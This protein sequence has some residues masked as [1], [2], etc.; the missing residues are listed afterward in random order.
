M[1]GIAGYLGAEAGD[2]AIIARQL[3][4]LAHRGPDSSGW[5]SGTGSIVGQTRLAIIDLVTGDPPI[6]NEDGSIAV[7]LNGEIY[8]FAEL[9]EGLAA[10]G[11]RLATRG[12]TEV[13][14]HLAEDL[15]PRDLAGALDGMFAFAVWDGPRRRLVL[16]RDR[17]GKKPLYYWH[18][19]G[20]FVF[21]SEIKALRTH[22]A[23]H[24]SFDE[25][26]LSEYLTLGYVATPR[27]F[28]EGIFSVPPGHVL[29][30]EEG[31]EPV[32]E[33]YWA[34]EVATDPA[35][36]LDLPY[37]QLVRRTRE[38]LVQGVERRL[39]SDVPLGAFLSGGVDS[40]AIVAIMSK[41][42]GHP[43][44]TFTIGFEDTEGF[45]ERPYADLVARH[46]GV[47]HRDFKVEPR[48]I[49]LIEELVWLHDQPFGD[50]SAIPTYLLAQLTRR[51]VT[52]ALSGDGGDEV[53]AGYERFAAAV[54]LERYRA[55]PTLLR[56][57]FEALV[58]A[59][60]PTAARGN[61]RSAQRFLARA[62]TP[63]PEAYISWLS[64]V[65]GDRIPDLVGSPSSRGIENYRAVWDESRG[66][67]L[68]DRL[69]YTNLRTYLVDDLLVKA[70][71]MSMAHGLE[72]RSPFLDKDLVEFAFR[73]P[74]DARMKRLTLKR[75][76]K[77][78]VRDLLPPEILKRRK[79]GFGV[80]LDRWFRTEIRPYVAEMLGAP[81][82]QVKQYLKPEGV[83]ALVAE[84]EGGKNHGH[85]LWALLT[86]EVWLRKE[87]P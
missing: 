4:L 23:V 27:T 78:A 72:V 65:D 10:R 82:A 69:L 60:P 70:D 86:L 75:V 3:G 42:L 53:F 36:K 24:A 46:L 19:G 77:D 35:D 84:H 52:V 14:A 18:G 30:V 81:G 58:R 33:R 2:E 11:H 28:Y 7:A 74:R 12:D 64:L 50:S 41:E 62:H 73:L 32:L 44:Q 39:V 59:L 83:D 22:P 1:C 87:A 54:A 47:E 6:A 25:S 71:R 57:P 55:L 68:L 16:G 51:H 85:V 13:I 63:L 20:S 76:L 80:P 29:I 61:V 8:N 66:G 38:L 9:R 40:S 15:S 79:R 26:V 48:A 67:E 56:R 43:T 21:G 5:T 49:D 17:F 45:D 31:S 37:P 34:P